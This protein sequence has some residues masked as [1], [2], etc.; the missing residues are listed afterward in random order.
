M[1]NEKAKCANSNDNREKP[2]N[3]MIEKTLRSVSKVEVSEGK[4][5]EKVAFSS[6]REPS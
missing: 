5:L 1:K 3:S 2:N 4:L 6:G